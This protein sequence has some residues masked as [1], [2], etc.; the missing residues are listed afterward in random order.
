MSTEPTVPVEDKLNLDSIKEIMDGFDPASLLPRLETVFENV[1][2]ACRIAVLAG[3]VL[4]LVLGLVYLFLSP[5]EAN[6]YV[7]YR[8]Y[9]GMGSVQAW[10]YTQRLAGIIFGG[11]GLVL[12]AL[13]LLFTCSFA[14]MEPGTMVFVAL[15]Y[16]LWEAGLAL[17]ANLAIMITTTLVFDRKGEYRR[18]R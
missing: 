17:A 8:C 1:H 7:G 15:R 12:T 4:L 16:L 6:H 11:L 9:F 5:K 3:P 13:M 18:R 2:T 14:T 10:R